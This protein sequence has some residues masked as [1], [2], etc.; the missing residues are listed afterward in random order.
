MKR[1]IHR[2]YGKK[3][4]C[5]GVA[6]F[7]DAVR[8]NDD[9]LSTFSRPEERIGGS[10]REC[11]FEKLTS[12]VW[13]SKLSRRELEI[14]SFTIDYQ[15]FPYR[16][17]ESKDVDRMPRSTTESLERIQKDISHCAKAGKVDGC[18]RDREVS[19]RNTFHY[20]LS[21]SLS[22]TRFLYS[23]SSILII[24]ISSPFRVSPTRWTSIPVPYFFL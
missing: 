15:N 11:R 20:P 21:L 17:N 2:Q 13:V 3:R 1:A 9:T 24:P 5:H 8:Y 7:V 23:A 4:H 22:R 14:N 19:A 6:L 16:G 12:K 10:Y 18:K